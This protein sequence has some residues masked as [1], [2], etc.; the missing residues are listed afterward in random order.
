[1]SPKFLLSSIYVFVVIHYATLF[2]SLSF[3][4]T[5]V[6]RLYNFVYLENLHKV[7]STNIHTHIYNGKCIEMCCY[8]HF[9]IN[10][11]ATHNSYRVS[12]TSKL[13]LYSDGVIFETIPLYVYI[14]TN[15]TF[16]FKVCMYTEAF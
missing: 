11:P 3:L 2:A 12:S 16:A 10:R 13:R 5:F 4:P 1:M 14:K 6:E 9:L 7:A 15:N 8:H